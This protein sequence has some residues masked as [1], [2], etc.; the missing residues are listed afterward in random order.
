M[1]YKKYYDILGVSKDAS[2]EAIKK[3]YRKLAVKHHPDKNPNN[4]KA[5][6]R[7]KEINEAYEVLKDP[8]KRE[9]YD[10]L[11]AN[12]K[13]YEHAG[14]GGGGFDWSQFGG[15]GGGRTYHFEGDAGD[16]FGG[17]GGFSDFFNAFFGGMG[18]FDNM[19]GA[20]TEDFRS[21][22]QVKGRD[23]RA[24][25]DLS[26]HEAYH[27]ISKILNIDGQK[28]KIN[29]KPGAYSGQELRLKN[30]G[31]SSPSGGEK[32][33]LYLKINVIPGAGDQIEGQN[34]I[35]E[36]PVD[37]YT[38]VLGGKL[39]VNTPAGK[40]N[41]TVP[42]STQPG[43][44]L[45]LKGKGMPV[46]GQKDKHGDLLIRLKIQI[47]KDLTTEEIGLFQKLKN[48]EQKK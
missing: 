34:L 7:F 17:A 32:G 21:Q 45:R 30:K 12:W 48:M 14:A 2:Q 13:Q 19:R 20:T 18:G 43:T 15:R 38:A 41:I 33:D 11:G 1:Q 29:I 4:K 35:K 22:R 40:I 9:K 42:K 39:Q 25:L 36:M 16:V 28:L 37:L 24:Q 46:Y 8:E 3:A 31:A 10:R 26:L 23:L 44:T 27:G 47:P 6:E 5:E